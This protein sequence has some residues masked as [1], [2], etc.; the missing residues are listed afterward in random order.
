M[1]CIDDLSTYV[2][3]LVAAVRTE[4]VGDEGARKRLLVGFA[5][6]EHE[7]EAPCTVWAGE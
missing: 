1:E 7:F 6:V 5:F 2:G 4:Q 3:V